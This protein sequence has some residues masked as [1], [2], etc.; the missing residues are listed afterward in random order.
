MENEG[1]RNERV[2]EYENKKQKEIDGVVGGGNKRSVK[3][4]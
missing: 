2:V 1:P 3:E 4:G